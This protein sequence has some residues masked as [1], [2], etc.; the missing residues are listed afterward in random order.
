MTAHR[1]IPI[2]HLNR[3][4]Y[5]GRVTWHALVKISSAL[6]NPDKTGIGKDN[7]CAAVRVIFG[8]NPHMLFWKSSTQCA[9][10]LV[11]ATLLVACTVGKNYQKPD[12]NA[13]DDWSELDASGLTNG[14]L[15]KKALNSWWKTFDDRKLNDLVNRAVADNLSLKAATSRLM[16]ARSQRV[17]AGS[18]RFPTI[19]A[20]GDLIR[21]EFSQTSRTPFPTGTI[22]S[23]GFDAAWE[24]DL[25]G[26]IRRQVEAAK[27]NVGA[28]MESY[29]DVRVTLL[30]EVALNYTEIRAYQARLT[31]AE[32]HR[33]TQA[34][35]MDLVEANVRGGEVSPLDLTQARSNLETTRSQIPVIETALSRAQHRL[36]VL[37]GQ[38]PGS[39]ANELRERRQIPVAPANIAVG[40][41]AE[42][43]RRRPDVRRA[44]RELAAQTAKVGVA[45]AELY[46]KLTLIGTI[47]LESLNSGNL[48][49]SASSVFNVG[50]SATWNIFSAGRVRQNIAIQ[51]AR[52]EQAL[53]AYESTILNA[54]RDVEDALVSYGK[55][56]VRRDSLTK[57]EASTKESVR[58]AQDLYQ[59]GETD[60]LTVL[61]AQRSLFRVQDQLT[62]SNAQVT[63]NIIMLYKALGGGW[64]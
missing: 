17:V 45:V 59:G 14:Q 53:I 54:L 62:Q 41:P 60:F 13:P 29:G 48:V 42:V 22:Y 24:L 46:P 56:M 31:V 11:M 57:A 64:Q 58:I 10:V 51:N 32:A 63:T 6:W 34:K 30:A 27:A 49:N 18:A 2:L 15:D 52:Q 47:G 20:T 23:G 9:P 44:E 39:L 8:H 37:L 61:D 4:P 21:T 26:G 38:T 28:K 1:V 7:I 25:F 40:I 55:E 3:A 43:L 50:P 35:T 19:N 5:I 33:D 12:I 36:A 16:E